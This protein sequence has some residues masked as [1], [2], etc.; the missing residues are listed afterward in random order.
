[1]AAI[2]LGTGISTL[3]RGHTTYPNWRGAPVFAPAVIVGGVLLLV[4][5][6]RPNDSARQ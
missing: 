2:F 1:M 6:L 4:F 5:A 3:F